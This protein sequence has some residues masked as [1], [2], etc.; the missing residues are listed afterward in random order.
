ML[1]NLQRCN[2]VGDKQKKRK[3]IDT[4]ID[5][6]KDFIDLD[7]DTDI[8]PYKK[9][10]SPEAFT[11][12][13]SLNIMARHY[14]ELEKM[15]EEHPNTKKEIKELSQKMKRNIDVFNRVSIKNW[16]EKNRWEPIEKQTYDVDI[17]TEK[18]TAEIGCQTMPWSMDTNNKVSTLEDINSIETWNLVEGREWNKE[19]FTN[20]EICIGNPL[21]TEDAVVKTVIIEPNDLNMEKSIQKLYCNKYPE[22]KNLKGDFEVIEQT[23]RIRTKDPHE[24][25]NRKIVKLTYDGTDSNIW[26]Q[27]TKLREETKEDKEVAI[28]HL[29]NMTTLRLMKMT[30]AI[31]H[32]SYTKVYIYTTRT[33]NLPQTKR[34]RERET[35][36]D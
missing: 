17:Q 1:G 21:D 28:H 30:E 5:I 8:D 14:K 24:I 22:I 7:D 9:R 18:R 25:I 33:V 13:E 4:S 10:E 11:I 35:H 27:L 15:I 36:M 3:L 2:S 26:D 16:L 20:T 34:E 12:I 32:G 31:Y 29:N 23:I 19:L 6:S